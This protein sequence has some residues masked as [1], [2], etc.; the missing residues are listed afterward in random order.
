MAATALFHVPPMMLS[1]MRAAALS[2]V[3]KYSSTRRSASC[4]LA[5]R[6]S[7]IDRKTLSTV[8]VSAPAAN[9]L[10]H[11][12]LRRWRSVLVGAGSSSA[13][14]T[15]AAAAFSV[16]DNYSVR[17]RNQRGS[18]RGRRHKRACAECA[19]AKRASAGARGLFH[20]GDHRRLVQGRAAGY[21]T[22][23]GFHHTST[24]AV[25]PRIVGSPV[26]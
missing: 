11:L 25:C 14:P 15:A 17:G 23:E 3:A 13:V 26:P 16:K 22:L 6:S 4:P 19:G 8:L 1:R 21:A 12:R 24:T 5:P 10:R 20:R 18:E 7:S 9:L 2:S